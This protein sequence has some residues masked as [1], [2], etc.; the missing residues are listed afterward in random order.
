M[1]D[2]IAADADPRSRQRRAAILLHR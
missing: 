2:D 1:T